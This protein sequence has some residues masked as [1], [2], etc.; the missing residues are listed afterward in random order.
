MYLTKNWMVLVK[1][2]VFNKM[3]RFLVKTFH[4]FLIEKGFS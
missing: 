1:K 4:S 3:K 2:N